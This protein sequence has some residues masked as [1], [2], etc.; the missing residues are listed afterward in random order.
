MGRYAGC[1]N[2]VVRAMVFRADHVTPRKTGGFS[3]GTLEGQQR[4]PLAA[5]E[6]GFRNCDVLAGVAVL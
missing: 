5:A 1:E 4:Y 2:A 3:S 6:Q